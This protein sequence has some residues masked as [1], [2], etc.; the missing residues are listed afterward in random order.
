MET[1]IFKNYQDFLKRED[2][3]VNGVSPEFAKNNPNYKE[4]NCSNR[5]CYNC[6]YCSNCSDCSYCSNCSDCSYCSYCSYCSD[7]SYC[8]YCSYCSDC[9]YCYYCYDCSYCSN[10]SYC[11][12][13]SDCSDCHYCSDC[14]DCS[15]CSDLRN[16]KGEDA[17]KAFSVPVIENIHS[18]ILE[19][20]SKE[21]ALKMNDWHTCSTIHCRAGW[22]VHLSGKEGYKLEK[23]TST[24]F[25]AMQIYK[26]SSDIK[27]SPTEFFKSEVEA[28]KDINRCA[29]LEKTNNN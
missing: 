17:D 6:S 22:V 9:S 7:C 4:M 25:A 16:K 21:N 20:A 29:E 1:Q 3:K 23:E 8:S 26:A 12:Y 15:N 5:G 11:S 18:K 24:L 13:C 27:V 10:C 28:M 14:S 2:R 19:A